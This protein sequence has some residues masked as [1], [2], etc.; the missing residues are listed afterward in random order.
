MLKK[1]KKINIHIFSIKKHIVQIIFLSFMIGLILFSNNNIAAAKNGLKLWSNNVVPSLFPF[2]VAVHLLSYTNICEKISKICYKFMRPLFNVP[3]SGAYAFILGLISGYPV[4]AKIVADLR[5]SGNCTKN[6]GSRMLA[7]TNNSSLLFIVGTVGISL[8]KNSTIGILLL[9]THILSSI[10][11]G[12]ILGLISKKNDKTSSQLLKGKE[13]KKICT[14]F[15]LGDIL[16][17]SIIS[18]I[19]TILLIGGF[20]IIFSCLISILNE[21]KFFY[22]LT[23][24]LTPICNILK[25]PS[26]FISSFFTGILEL[27]NG[28]HLVSN[29][30]CKHISINIIVTAFLLGFGGISVFLQVFSI[31]SKSDLSIKPYIYGKLLQGIIA[32]LYTYILIYSFNFFNF[33]L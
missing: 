3:G 19:K 16:A 13:P 21:S 6:E 26:S 20:V 18:S 5:N 9:I 1:S 23:L 24:V 31:I 27:T 30:A 11:V 12:I 32:S 14:F 17:S 33:N 4:G 8:F 25:I 22:I 28:A 2:F 29:I 7:F 15:N 10:T